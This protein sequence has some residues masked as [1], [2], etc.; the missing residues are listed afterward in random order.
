M[1]MRLVMSYRYWESLHR[2]ALKDSFGGRLCFGAGKQK[3]FCQVER[4]FTPQPESKNMQLKIWMQKRLDISLESFTISPKDIESYVKLCESKALAG[5]C[6][7]N[8]DLCKTWAAALRQMSKTVWRA[9]LSAGWK[10]CNS[11]NLFLEATPSS[12]SCKGF[13]KVGHTYLRTRVLELI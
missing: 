10:L 13:L 5:R 4:R 6:W 7:F 8:C 12:S 9:T 2:Q 1:L 11:F 3:L